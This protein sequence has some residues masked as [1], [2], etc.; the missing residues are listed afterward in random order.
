[1]VTGDDVPGLL[2]P[3]KDFF[4][5][6]QFSVRSELR[7]VTCHYYKDNGVNIID[8]F[9]CPPQVFISAAAPY[10]GVSDQGEA[11]TARLPA[12][13]QGAEKKTK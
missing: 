8:I 6:K 7:H 1:M 5:E 12:E 10:M 2:K 3:V 11:E 4:C 9:Y 13:K